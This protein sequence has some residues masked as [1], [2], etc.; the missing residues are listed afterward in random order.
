M[1]SAI[2]MPVKATIAPRRSVA[3][4]ALLAIAMV[5]A[6]YIFVIIL[7]A[8]C[9]YVPYWILENADHAPGQILLLLLGGVVIA[10]AMLWSLIPR[11][12][13]F[14]PPGP[15]LQHSSHPRFF[16]ELD[17]IAASLNEPLPREVYLI[18][19]VNAFV[20][21]RGGI[22]GFGSRRIMAI[23]LPLLSILTISEFR[24]VLAH[25][26]AHYYSGD[27]TLGPFV[28]KTQS[29]MIRTF[30]NIGSIQ[31]LNRI[32]VISLLSSGV[33]FVLKHYFILFVRVINFV[34]RKKEYRADELACLVAGVEPFIQGLRRIHGAGMAWPAY[35]NT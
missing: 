13:R 9:V 8:A 2:P 26:F 5:L 1:M 28:H 6:S 14:E 17:N 22:L 19:Q 30:Q 21:D 23:G 10:G 29:A 4:F 11:R 12:D 32:A 35:W 7:A 33:T 24:G 3:L 16:A 20:A 34:S 18:G 31:E 15:P 27:T 25:E